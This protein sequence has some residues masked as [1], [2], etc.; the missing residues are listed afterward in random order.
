MLFRAQMDVAA[1]TFQDIDRLECFHLAYREEEFLN[2]YIS[3]TIQC[4][5]WHSIFMDVEPIY[6]QCMRHVRCMIL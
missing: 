6:P 2:V 3:P 1:L 4:I 5:V